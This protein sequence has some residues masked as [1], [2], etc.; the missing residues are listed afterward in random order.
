MPRPPLWPRV[1][2]VLSIVAALIV[3]VFIR[4]FVT[5]AR[6]SPPVSVLS[7]PIL[8]TVVNAEIAPTRPTGESRHASQ[9]SNS[10]DALL[11][12]GAK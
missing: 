4:E 2:L 8:L 3:I 7:G 5:T 12:L 10:S 9:A 6:Q 11:E 1:R